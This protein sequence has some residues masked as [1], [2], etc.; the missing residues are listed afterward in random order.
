MNRGTGKRCN[1]GCR[2]VIG[3]HCFEVNIV[4][5]QGS[6]VPLAWNTVY[7]AVHHLP[8]ELRRYK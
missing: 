8:K 1:C 3:E 7:Y 5:L 6:K 4:A 2:G